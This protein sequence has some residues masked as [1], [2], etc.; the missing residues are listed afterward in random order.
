MVA[1]YA[2]PTVVVTHTS[3]GS[4]GRSSQTQAL[5]AFGRSGNPPL[6]PPHTPPSPPLHPFALLGL[7]PL[8]VG[9]QV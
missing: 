4:D 6:R 9:D 5:L 3:E 1:K 7:L 8:S 2:E